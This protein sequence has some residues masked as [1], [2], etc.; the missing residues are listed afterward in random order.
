MFELGLHP[1]VGMFTGKSKMI[2]HNGDH[3]QF[4]IDNANVPKED[5]PDWPLPS[6]DAN[7]WANA[8]VKAHPGFDVDEARSWFANALMRG[9][10]ERSA[11]IAE[12]G[13]DVL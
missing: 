8:F 2:I 10:D 12:K 4:E 1:V 11:R 9:Y 5:R 13:T 3:A 6:F 7:D